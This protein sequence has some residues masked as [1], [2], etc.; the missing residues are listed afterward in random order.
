MARRRIFAW[1][2]DG[3]SSG[4]APTGLGDS[5]YDSFAP[6]TGDY[7]H[8]R[9]DLDLNWRTVHLNANGG[10]GV[11]AWIWNHHGPLRPTIGTSPQYPNPSLDW[12]EGFHVGLD[13]NTA[14][15][16]HLNGIWP[17]E[18]FGPEHSFLLHAHGDP[19]NVLGGSPAATLDPSLTF[20]VGDYFARLI[21][22]DADVLGQIVAIATVSGSTVRITLSRAHGITIAQ[23]RDVWIYGLG[24]GPTGTP[25][26][27]NLRGKHTATAATS[28]AIDVTLGAPWNGNPGKLPG[29]IVFSPARRLNSL[30]IARDNVLRAGWTGPALIAQPLGARSLRGNLQHVYLSD[31]TGTV[32]PLNGCKRYVE[33]TLGWR[34]IIR[35]DIGVAVALTIAAGAKTYTI[36]SG[37]WTT[38]PAA[39]DAIRVV[40]TTHGDGMFVLGA[41]TSTV[42]TL[43][44]SMRIFRDE[45]AASARVELLSASVV[46]A[47]STKTLTKASGTWDVTPT[48]GQT[49]VVEGTTSNNGTRTV[50][51][52]T[53]TVITVSESVANETTNCELYLANQVEWDHGA[54][55]NLTGW[56]SDGWVIDYGLWGSVFADA[57]GGETPLGRAVA[58]YTQTQAAGASF[59]SGDT[60]APDCVALSLGWTDVFASNGTIEQT[61]LFASYGDALEE[62]I[63]EIRTR[64]AAAASYVTTAAEVPVVVVNFGPSPE[65][66]ATEPGVKNEAGQ[67]LAHVLS[68]RLQTQ[69][70]VARFSLATLV[71]TEDLAHVAG[72]LFLSASSEIDLGVR[73]WTALER[74]RAGTLTT[75]TGQGVPFYVLIGQSQTMGTN[76]N[77]AATFD[78]DPD[79][80]GEWYDGVG[81]NFAGGG[82]DDP[83]IDRPR[84]CW[85]W[86]PVEGEF[87]ELAPQKNSNRY[88]ARVLANHGGGTP[89][90]DTG[91]FTSGPGFGTVGPEP[92]LI[93]SLRKRH[94]EGVFLYKLAVGGAALAQVPGLPTFDPLASDLAVDL[95]EDFRAIRAWF[96]EHGL[97]PDTRAIF[98][99]IG[100][101][102]LFQPWSRQ[103]AADLDR[104]IVWSRG[105][106]RTSS[107]SRKEIPFVIGRVQSHDRMSAGWTAEAPFVQAAVDDTPNR[108]T[109]IGIANM[110]GLPLKGDAVHRT[111]RAVIEAGYRL[112]DALDQTSHDDDG[113]NI[114][115]G[116]Q[117]NPEMQAGTAEA[118]SPESASASSGNAPEN[119]NA[120]ASTPTIAAGVASGD[121]LASVDLAIKAFS[122]DGFLQ[123]YSVDGFSATRAQLP[124]LMKLRANLRDEAASARG[125]QMLIARRGRY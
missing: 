109:N 92:S 125:P 123:S 103:F 110:Q 32:T 77:A 54:A 1:I 23:T 25:A 119:A 86:D 51:S 114:D 116:A 55:P 84:Q 5:A 70:A 67:L 46:F 66:S 43:A 27:S 58:L 16:P 100:E 124:D 101:S 17:S 35:Q 113:F 30:A 42:L 8:A 41:A 98:C 81:A 75:P 90:S 64:L 68:I 50:V 72:G 3:I 11:S 34:P 4:H 21:P 10:I 44:S 24:R 88:N 60:F 112:S 108:L 57:A 83:P 104:F 40:G 71:D 12:F 85:I 18:R 2:G 121:L 82:Y 79:F 39:G 73:V 76:N 97:F 6:G 31:I 33:H 29:G 102:H 105:V 78:E 22:Q 13:W 106:F 36:G 20:Q 19:G 52:A 61:I 117:I 115:E 99:D 80:N 95:V 49:I 59:L 65:S 9:G 26:D 69:Q 111:Y 63:G 107:T 93:L 122:D 74:L 48:A 7:I 38:T 56:N 94:P 91:G 28:T 62:T 37:T 47:A 96:H 45:S 89:G 14:T 118:G 53:S 120:G 15:D 87:Q